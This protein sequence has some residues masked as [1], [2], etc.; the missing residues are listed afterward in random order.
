MLL[1]LLELLRL[2][3]LLRLLA[4]GCER[5]LLLAELLRRVERES[6][7]PRREGQVVAVE[8]PCPLL[9]LALPLLRR[10]AECSERD[11]VGT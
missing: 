10:R 9:P 11:V 2:L 6:G 3:K 8:Q 4:E 5:L 7:R 1:L